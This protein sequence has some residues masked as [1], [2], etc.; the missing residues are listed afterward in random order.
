MSD[1][2][3]VSVWG[4]CAYERVREIIV[5]LENFAYVLNP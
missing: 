1:A 2:V 5:N 3:M 4:T